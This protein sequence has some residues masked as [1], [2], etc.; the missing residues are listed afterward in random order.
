MLSHKKTIC[1]KDS[2]VF[3][4]SLMEFNVNI[5][6]QKAAWKYSEFLKF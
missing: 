6:V 4:K 3:E 5:S 1:Y 2:K